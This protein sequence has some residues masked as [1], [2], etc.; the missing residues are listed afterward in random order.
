MPEEKR[1]IESTEVI[2]DLSIDCIIFGFQESVLK[3]LLVKHAEGIIKDRWAL[4]GGFVT[5]D[6]NIDSSAYRLLKDLTGVEE[7]YLEQLQAFGEVDR[8][9][10]RR[11]ITIAYYALTRPEN[12]QLH[13]GFTA[14]DAQWLGIQE[15]QALPYDHNKILQFAWQRLKQKV[16][17]EP[18]GFNLLPEK[19]T[20][21]QLQDPYEAILEVK[22]DKPNFRR[23]IMK[24]D[25]LISCNEKQKGVSHR[26]ANLYRF[27]KLVYD[28]LKKEGFIF[29]F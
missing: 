27:D 2:E 16:K 12:Y 28:R 19:F 14:S 24:M 25:L 11:V 22:L 26:A 13:P 8:Y 1:R 7:L 15:I 6:E 3:V 29:E 21:L 10:T 17:F 18:I 5:Y 9:P 4:P 23:K 20:L